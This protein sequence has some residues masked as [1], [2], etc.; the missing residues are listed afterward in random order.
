MKIVLIHSPINTEKTLGKIKNLNPSIPPTGLACLAGYLREKGVDVAVMD[1]YK[2]NLTADETVEKF[3]Q[4]GADIAGLSVSTPGAPVAHEIARKIKRRNPKIITIFGGVHPTLMPKETTSDE[5][6]DFVVRGEG[7]LVLTELLQTIKQNGD[8]KQVRGISYGKGSEYHQNQNKEIIKNLDTLPLP[9]WDL[10]DLKKYTPPPHWDLGVPFVS[11]PIL[12]GCPHRC[13][14][15]CLP[16]GKTPRTLSV[17]RA[18][19]YINHAVNKLG[20]K[21]IMFNPLFPGGKFGKEFCQKIIEARLNKKFSWLAEIRVDYVDE[22]LLNLMK[23]AGCKRVAFG[24]ESGVQSILDGIKKGINLEQVRKAVKL[25]K[26][27]GIEIIA[28]FILGLPGET[29]DLSE[30]TIRFAKELNPDYVKFNLAVPYP[31]TEMYDQALKDGLIQSMDWE[32]FTSFSSMTAYEPIYTPKGMVPAE[33]MKLQKTALK[34]FYMRPSYI[35]KRILKL[36]SKRELMNVLR[37]G[38]SLIKGLRN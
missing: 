35:L 30:Q 26:K 10:F 33:L 28:Y 12:R 29:K 15:C 16:L 1:A 13:T 32:R 3:F 31:G 17:N 34:E 22:G 36:R 18:T 5:A 25:T 38:L 9:A 6:V 37:A 23:E 24:I 8:F 2:D 19:E 20:V 27:A 21:A 11:I 7:E 14:F 4:E